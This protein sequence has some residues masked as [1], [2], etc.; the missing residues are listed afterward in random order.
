MSEVLG[1]CE[2]SNTVLSFIKLITKDY[3][4]RH[5]LLDMLIKVLQNKRKL[6]LSE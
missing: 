6:L 1:K 5:I 2:D 3:S 4:H